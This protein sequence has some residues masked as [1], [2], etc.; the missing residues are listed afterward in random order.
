[1]CRVERQGPWVVGSDFVCVASR[2]V[3][4]EDRRH[5]TL[6]FL[7]TGD[8][9]RTDC[10]MRDVFDAVAEGVAVSLKIVVGTPQE[11]P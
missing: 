4:L 8:S 10:R 9:I 3:G 11:Q 1:M 5:G 6:I 7:D 2:V